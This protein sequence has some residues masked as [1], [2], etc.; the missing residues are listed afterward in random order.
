MNFINVPKPFCVIDPRN[1]YPNSLSADFYKKPDLKQALE[2]SIVT[3]NIDEACRWAIEHHISIGLMDEFWHEI[4]YLASKHINVNQSLSFYSWLIDKRDKWQQTADWLNT[5]F[6]NELRNNQES[7]NSIC[8]VAIVMALLDKN[9]Y[10]SFVPPITLKDFQ[11]NVIQG[12][13]TTDCFDNVEGYMNQ[14][15]DTEVVMALS[16][17][18]NILTCNLNTSAMYWVYWLEKLGS[19]KRK[20]KQTIYCHPREVKGVNR[21]YWGDWIWILWTLLIDISKSV[22]TETERDIQL[23]CD[24]FKWEYKQSLRKQKLFFVCHA[25]LLIKCKMNSTPHHNVNANNEYFGVAEV[26]SKKQYQQ[27]LQ[28]IGGINVMYK[29][30]FHEMVNHPDFGLID[31]EEYWIKLKKP[32]TNTK[33]KKYLAEFEKKFDPE[34][35]QEKQK[36]DLLNSIIPKQSK[37]QMQEHTRVG[38]DYNN[39]TSGV[40]LA[41]F[42][43]NPTE[44][45][46]VELDETDKRIR[47]DLLYLMNSNIRNKVTNSSQPSV[48]DNIKTLEV[49]IPHVQQSGSQYQTGDDLYIDSDESDEGMRQ[50]FK[51]RRRQQ[52]ADEL[53]IH[54]IVM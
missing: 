22:S 48:V 42:H 23:L 13:L 3:G 10:L 11:D 14:K 36:N 30:V 26:L 40:H 54:E 44:T 31:I 4:F 51:E 41:S 38:N 6:R 12:Y 28:T 1:K 35:V 37:Q 21:A 25:I 32:I 15:D 5:K 24:L 53:N 33:Y 45:K 18:Y 8:E 43:N 9:K 16:E 46:E 19:L 47:D 17:I 50:S 29:T 52:D 2:H 20:Q 39:M 27:Y 49:G 34:R 7:R